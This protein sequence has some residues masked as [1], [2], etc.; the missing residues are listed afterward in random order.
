MPLFELYF[1]GCPVLGTGA[2]NGRFHVTDGILWRV[3]GGRTIEFIRPTLRQ[4]AKDGAP[5]HLRL[6]NRKAT[7]TL[8]FGS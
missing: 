3:E 8:L 7:A 4:N 6:F 5:E 2:F 1:S